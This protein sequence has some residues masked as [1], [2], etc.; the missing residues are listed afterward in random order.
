MTI[1]SIHD[2]LV[3]P[4]IYSPTKLPVMPTNPPDKD[5]DITKH[6]VDIKGITNMHVHV[7]GNNNDA[8]EFVGNKDHDNNTQWPITK[9]M[10][11]FIAKNNN[12][13]KKY[14]PIVIPY[15]AACYICNEDKHKKSKKIFKILFIV[16]FIIVVII[17]IIYINK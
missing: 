3:K 15:N 4:N 6:I 10:S 8:I 11:K 9:E 13:N 17:A 16:V 2:E 12:L 7:I 1:T 14:L 5:T